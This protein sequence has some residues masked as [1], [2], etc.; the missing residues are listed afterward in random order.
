MGSCYQ[1]GRE[2]QANTAAQARFFLPSPAAALL[3]RYLFPP[4]SQRPHELVYATRKREL[5][6]V[7]QRQGVSVKKVQ[8]RLLRCGFQEVPV[9]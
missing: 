2:R 4:V 3:A 1:A 7:P 6:T 9:R 8:H 5:A